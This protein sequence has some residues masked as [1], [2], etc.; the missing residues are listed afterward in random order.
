M[1]RHGTISTGRRL[2]AS[3]SLRRRKPKETLTLP[4]KVKLAPDV[5][6]DVDERLRRGA[7][8]I[9][10]LA[11]GRNECWEFFRNNTYTVRTKENKLVVTASGIST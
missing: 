7:A 6:P 2:R 11:P 8:R 4:V 10:E 9:S 5:P 1:T 3:G